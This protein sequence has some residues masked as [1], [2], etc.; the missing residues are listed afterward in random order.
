MRRA[1]AVVLC[2]TASLVV[3]CRRPEKL[4]E[5]ALIVFGIDGMDPRFL[6]RHWDQL[7]TLRKLRDTGG[8]RRLQTTTPPQS[9]VAWST[10]ITGL[11]PDGHGI[12]DF[13][14]R[15][16]KTLTPFS[17]MSR[18]EPPRWQLPVGPWIFPL[19]SAHVISLRNGTPFWSLLADHGVPVVT[20]RMPTNFPPA[21]GGDAISGMG[22]PDL[23]GGFGTFTLYTDEP[24]EIPRS[25]PGGEIVGVTVGDDGRV[26]LP[27]HGPVNPLRRD[28]R[29]T[30]TNLTADL[31]ANGNAIRISVGDEAVILQA[32]EWSGWIHVEFPLVPGLVS[33]SGMIRLYAKTI[34]PTLRLY[35]SPINIDPRVPAIPISAPSTLAPTIAKESGPFYTQGIAQ[36]TAAVRHGALSL[37]EYKIQSR[38]VFEDELR[39]LRRA[40]GAFHG[41]FLFAYFSSVDQDSHM[42][43]ER[44]EAGLLETYRR[45][46]DAIRET[47]RAVPN[48]TFVVM[49][50]H[51]FAP[52]R[53]SFQLNAWLV[54]EGFL[55]LSGP[56]AGEGFQNVDWSRTQAY[57]L[58]LNGLYLNLRGREAKGIVGSDERAATIDRI[59]TRLLD[60][61]D[62]LTGERIVATVRQPKH[63]RAPDLIIG[64]N[65]GYRAAWNT[66]LGATE[67]QVIEENQEP[68]V[69]DH[70]IDPDAVPGVLLSSRSLGIEA[71]T[72]RDLPTSILH[73]FHVSPPAAMSGRK[74]F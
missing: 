28:E 31:D 20:L 1:S 47:M 21:Q 68:W 54:Q 62:S 23:R 26:V 42:L 34:R 52:F 15:D 4:S 2:I 14:H 22:V 60:A 44:D 37:D 27:L 8:F 63:P 51:G 24:E 55:S 38:M 16:P 33:T 10:F 64:Y 74:V 35:T 50:D 43:W 53:R 70:C 5:D 40:V 12:Y 6:E 9:P 7:P 36:D 67:G 46:D 69:G 13:V 65:A 19:S 11:D 73:F 56:A 41:G 59:G 17:S 18:T 48:A 57:A 49:S 61:R 3:C 25:V 58:G 29:R 71:P 45:I 66:G 32:G 72:L 30:S 39:L